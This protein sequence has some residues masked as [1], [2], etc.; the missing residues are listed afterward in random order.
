MAAEQQAHLARNLFETFMENSPVLLEGRRGGLRLFQ[1]RCYDWRK[2]RLHRDL[3]ALDCH[4]TRYERH[5]EVVKLHIFA[6]PGSNSVFPAVIIRS[7]APITVVFVGY[8]CHANCHGS[9]P[10][11]TQLSS[12]QRWLSSHLTPLFHL[13]EVNNLTIYFGGPSVG[14][15]NTIRRL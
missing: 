3:V 4:V 15:R 7:D 10:S 9:S 6:C 2:S 12:W 11:G 13:F 5:T 14:S 1:R 8:C